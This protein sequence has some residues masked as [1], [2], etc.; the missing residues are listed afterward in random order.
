[1]RLKIIAF[2]IALTIHG[3]LMTTFHLNTQSTSATLGL[4]LPSQTLH[5][6]ELVEN[7]FMPSKA[8]KHDK[9]NK[10]VTPKPVI[11]TTSSTTAEQGVLKKSLTP[12]KPKLKKESSPMPKQ[13]NNTQ[14]IVKP[15]TAPKEKVVNKQTVLKETKK[16]EVKK[17]PI[18]QVQKQKPLPIKQTND[19]QDKISPEIKTLQGNQRTV[20]KGVNTANSDHHLSTLWEQYKRQIFNTINNQQT[21][22]KQARLRRLQGQV[23]VEFTIASTGEI[24]T[25][26]LIQKSQVK[27]FNR[28]AKRLFAQLKLPPPPD[29]LASKFPTSMS[30]ILEYNL[31]Q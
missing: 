21:Y 24:K 1:M 9:P 2:L 19:K 17:A 8:E 20:N 14:K 30:I 18:Q 12:V 27:L 16:I 26:A 28:N 3:L 15:K 11:K 13:T 4:G 10:P 5:A 6:V 22:P 25:F 7:N 23:K 31:D 29:N